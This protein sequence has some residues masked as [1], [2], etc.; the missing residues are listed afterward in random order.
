MRKGT[1]KLVGGSGAA[2]GGP[3]QEGFCRL[4]YVIVLMSSFLSGPRHV[5]QWTSKFTR[6]LV[7]SSLGGEV[8]A[9]S[10]MVD[11][12][13]LI[14]EFYAP[15]VELPPGMVGLE[16]CESLRAPCVENRLRTKK[17]ITEK[18][19]VRHFLSSQQSLGN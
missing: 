14:R 5:L 4:G 2:N 17:M 15:C 10:E 3:S 9:F 19:L 8:Y 6:K 1:L 7:K 13:A 16:D 11:H 12:M 18:Y